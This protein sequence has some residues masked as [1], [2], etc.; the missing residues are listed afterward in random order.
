[1][2]SMIGQNG[3]RGLQTVA[4]IE[5]DPARAAKRRLTR[6][7]ISEQ[8]SQVLRS[9]RGSERSLGSR[10]SPYE[11]QAHRRLSTTRKAQWREYTV[12][13]GRSP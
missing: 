12:R 4:C 3:V 5:P 7:L 2:Y 6:W 10:C 8:Q 9:T 13:V 11:P 1:M